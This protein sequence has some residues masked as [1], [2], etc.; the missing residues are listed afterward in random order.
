MQTRLE[1]YKAQRERALRAKLTHP[2]M[3]LCRGPSIG[4]CPIHGPNENVIL[5]VEHAYWRI[6]PMGEHPDCKC[7]VRSVSK[8]EYQRLLDSGKVKLTLQEPQ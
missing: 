1:M 6:A 2:W 3:L 7:S 8:R 4:P 5:P